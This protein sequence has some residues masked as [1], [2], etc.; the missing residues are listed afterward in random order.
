MKNL[1]NL[2]KG[3]QELAAAYPPCDGRI[4][5]IVYGK[6]E[7]NNW[8]DVFEDGVR[9]KDGNTMTIEEF[10]ASFVPPSGYEDEDLEDVRI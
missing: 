10:E 4:R 8:V 3:M 7:N 2:L 1:I 6:G 9:G 5:V